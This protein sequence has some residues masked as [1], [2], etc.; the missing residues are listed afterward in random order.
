MEETVILRYVWRIRLQSSDFQGVSIEITAT[1]L[2]LVKDLDM[3]SSHSG[4]R[5][6]LNLDFCPIS[7]S[8]KE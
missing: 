1:V 6:L 5:L 4:P 2:F 8:L 3:L 7:Y